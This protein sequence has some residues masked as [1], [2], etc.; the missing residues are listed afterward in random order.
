MKSFSVMK[1]REIMSS[2]G[3]C[4][5]QVIIMLSRISQNYKFKHH[6]LMRKLHDTRTMEVEGGLFG[7]RRG[8]VGR[9]D[10]VMKVI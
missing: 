8:P 9:Q 3:E 7:R 2:T 4:T 6:F 1:N 10:R 5:K